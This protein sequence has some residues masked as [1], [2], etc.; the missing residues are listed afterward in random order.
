MPTPRKPQPFKIDDP[1]KL[2][3]VEKNRIIS[4]AEAVKL[5]SVSA[6]G[7]YRHFRHKLVPLTDKRV[8]VRLKDALFLPD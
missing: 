8:G 1:A 5:S 3:E 7:W 2:T 6:D 4:V